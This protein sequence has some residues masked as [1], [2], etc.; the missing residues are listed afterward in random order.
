MVVELHEELALAGPSPMV[1]QFQKEPT[2][3]GLLSAVVRLHDESTPAG[4]SSAVVQ[5]PEE[6]TPA[7]RSARDS[8]KL[9]LH[10]EPE[11]AKLPLLLRELDDRL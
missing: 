7:G 5:F 2:P 6:P 4:P 8:A 11:P 10:E 3:A 1:V 9:W